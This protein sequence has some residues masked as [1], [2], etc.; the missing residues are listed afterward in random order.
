MVG[1]FLLHIFSVLPGSS[2]L[3]LSFIID[4]LVLEP[5]PQI[6]ILLKFIDERISTTCYLSISLLATS[7]I[8]L[9][10]ERL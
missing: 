6:A 1:M 7:V 3:E 10:K 4:I 8:H 5:S 2:V 9:I